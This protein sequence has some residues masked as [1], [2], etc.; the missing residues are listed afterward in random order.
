M[1]KTIEDISSTKKRLVIEI[2]AEELEAA[3]KKSFDEVRRQAR[4]PG[5]RPGKAPMHMIEKRYGRSVE[6][7]IV[8]RAIPEHYGKAVKE[9]GIAPVGMPAIEGAVDFKRNHPLEFSLTVEVRPNLDALAYDGVRVTKLPTDVTDEDVSTALERLREDKAV[10]TPSEAA[11]VDGDIVIVDC[12]MKGSEKTYKDE[13]FRMTR[14]AMPA[15][16][17]ENLIGKKKGESAEFEAEFPADYTIRELAGLKDACAVAVKEVKNVSFPAL[18]EEFAKDLEFDTLDAL[19]AHVRA[20]IEESKKGHAARVQKGELMKNLVEMMDFEVPESLL[21]QELDHMVANAKVADPSRADDELRAEN[22]PRATRG[23][24]ASMIL[25]YV[26]EREKVEVAEDDI[27]RRVVEVAR[28]SRLTP[29]NVMKYYISK[30]GSLD[31]LR[32]QVRE[33]KVLDLLLERAAPV[34]PEA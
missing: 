33:D 23:V 16:F 5:F 29:E 1:L 6:S 30:D 26:A 34:D 2:P 3:A 11:I 21:G 9:A 25:D 14:D 28:A 27:R 17:Y 15:S 32:H 19:K 7:E 4:I 18:D 31:G 22:L 24:K 12:E 8:E 20:R 13:V 10:Y